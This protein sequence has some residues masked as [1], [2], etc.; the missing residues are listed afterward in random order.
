MPDDLRPVFAGKAPVVMTLDA[1]T[2]RIHWEMIAQPDIYSLSDS[3]ES[4]G[5]APLSDPLDSFLGT[6]RGFTRQLRTTFAPTPEPPPPPRRVLRVLVV[7]DPQEEDR[8]PGAEQEGREVAE[9]FRSFNKVW[10]L[11]NN[12]VEVSTLFGPAEATRQAVLFHLTRR[13]YDI[14]HYAG[15]CMFDENDHAASGWLFTGGQV[16]SADELNRIDHIP[17]FVFSNA[18]ESGIRPPP[19]RQPRPRGPP[20]SPRRSSPAVWPTSS[21]RRGS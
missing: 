16:L 7:A 13:H 14:L 6:S 19:R 21:A 3:R 4:A 9:L 18:C 5:Q 15:H 2:A 1:T 10:R 11:P 20:V 12:S 17:K 8:L